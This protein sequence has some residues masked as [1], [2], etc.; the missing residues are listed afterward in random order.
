MESVEMKKRVEADF[1]TPYCPPH[2]RR[3]L[4]YRRLRWEILAHP[5]VSLINGG[6][7]HQ[8]LRCLFGTADRIS[9]RISQRRSDKLHSA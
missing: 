9:D 2:K 3:W 6:P 7:T 4:F 5:H 8:D 1:W